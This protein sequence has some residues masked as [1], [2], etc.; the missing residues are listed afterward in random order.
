LHDGSRGSWICVGADPRCT[1]DHAAVPLEDCTARWEQATCGFWN[2]D[3][4][5]C[6]IWFGPR[7]NAEVTQN[8]RA[9]GS[10]LDAGAFFR[11]PG[12]TFVNL[13]FDIILG[14]CERGS[15]AADST[16]G[17]HDAR[18]FSGHQPTRQI[19]KA[20]K[21][22]GSSG[23]GNE[24][25][26]R[27]A[28]V[29]RETRVIDV[30]RRAIGAEDLGILSHVEIDVGV[31][32]RRAGAHAVELFDANEDALGTGIVGKMRDQCS[33][34]ATPFLRIQRFAGRTI[35]SMRQGW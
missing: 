10:D 19:W 26:F 6:R 33:G 28:L 1:V 27:I 15:N 23:V 7:R 22:I 14:E 12:A 13:R 32:E 20:R 29:R 5:C 2:V 24:T 16:A 9:V 3:V 17:D 8:A 25:A 11:K 35:P 18:S 21:F 30:K 34:H 4:D 31:I